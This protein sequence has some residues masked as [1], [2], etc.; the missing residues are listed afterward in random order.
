MTTHFPEL[1]GGS[2]EA[3]LEMNMQLLPQPT[4]DFNDAKRQYMEQYGSALV[5]NSY[6]QSRFSVFHIVA[7]GAVLLAFKTYSTF[8]NV[9]S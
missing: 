8:T 2:E 4:K 6:F 5:T 7:G 1:D 3:Y 9:R